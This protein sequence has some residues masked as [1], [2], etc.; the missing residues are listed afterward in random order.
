[1]WIDILLRTCNRPSIVRTAEHILYVGRTQEIGTNIGNLS[2]SLNHV[3]FKL[4]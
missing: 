1:M 4:S 3:V 2:R